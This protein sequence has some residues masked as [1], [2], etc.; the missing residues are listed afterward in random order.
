MGLA[1]TTSTTMMLAL[2]DALAVALLERRGFSERR[3][4]A[5]CIPAASSAGSCCASPTSCTPATR[6][7]SSPRGTRDGRGDPGD[8]R[9][10]LRLRR[11]HRWRRAGSSGIVTDGDLRRHMGDELLRAAVDEVMTQAAEDHPAAGARRRGAG[12][13]ERA[14]D[15]QPLRRRRDAGGRSA[16][17]TSTIACARGSHEGP[18][19]PADAFAPRPPARSRAAVSPRGATAASSRC[20]KRRAAGGRRGAAAAGRGLAAH[21][22]RV[23][24]ACIFRCRAS[25][26]ARRATCSMVNARYTGIDRDNRPFIVTADVGAPE[27]Q[28]RR[29]SSRSS[30]PKA[31][32]DHRRA[33]TGSS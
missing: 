22:E 21:R 29:T 12:P 19:E 32:S 30:G 27:A 9:E 33:A 6:C 3:F 10:E 14:G 24:A 11:R 17:C 25:T 26:S 15:H 13:D 8:D 1:P 23:R 16:S 18:A 4:P 5:S 7:R 20:A 28:A 2:G 31:R